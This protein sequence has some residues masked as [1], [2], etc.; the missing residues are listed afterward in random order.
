MVPR[1]ST[2]LE[3]ETS[4][5]I[6]FCLVSQTAATAALNIQKHPG[7]TRPIFLYAYV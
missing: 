2:K 1:N 3:S 6:L 5:T 4:F 7:N